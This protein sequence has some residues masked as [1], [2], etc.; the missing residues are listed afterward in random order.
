MS[1]ES[2]KIVLVVARTLWVVLAG[3]GSITVGAR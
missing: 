3:R 1:Q 2:L